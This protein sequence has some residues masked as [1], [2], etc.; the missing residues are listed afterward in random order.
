MDGWSKSEV[1]TLSRSVY[2][3]CVYAA[4]M[5]VDF[6]HPL[7]E[8][9]HCGYNGVVRLYSITVLVYTGLVQDFPAI[10][11]N[12]IWLPYLSAACLQ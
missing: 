1:V 5:L 4:V 3:A 7:V 8:V 2:C 10:T 12:C 6:A 11:S 9:Q